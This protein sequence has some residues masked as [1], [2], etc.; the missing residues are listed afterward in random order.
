MAVRDHSVVICVYTE[1]R[2]DQICAAVQSVREQ[3]LPCAEIIVVVDYNRGL[4]ERLVA[5]M[6]DVSVVENTDAK[7]LSGARNTGLARARGEF[8]AFLDDDATAHADWLKFIN[9]SFENPAITGVGGLT[10]P[11][12]ETARPWWMPEEFFWVVG[13]NYLGMP[14]SGAPVRNLLGGNMSFRREVFELVDGFQSGIGRT[15]GGRP[16]GCE[17]TEF[18]I[19][20]RQRSPAAVLIM[21]HRAMIWHYVSAKRCA[22]SYFLSRCY[23]EGISKAQVT[24]SVGTSAG[25]SAERVYVMRTL[26][27]GVFRGVGDLFRGRPAAIGQAGAI[28]A[29]ASVTAIGYFGAKLRRLLLSAIRRPGFKPPD[30]RLHPIGQRRGGPP[31]EFLRGPLPVERTAQELSWAR[32]RE[33]RLAAAAGKPCHQ[34]GEL[35]HVGLYPGADVPD[36]GLAV[37]GRRQ[38]GRH[39]IG[40]VDVVARLLA[41]AVDGEGLALKGVDGVDRDHAGLTGCA[42]AG[43]VHV[44]KTQDG[45]RGAEEPVVQ[46]DVLLGTV[47]RHAIGGAGRRERAFR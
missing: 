45:M 38:E 1:D 5:A 14:P 13:C 24:A 40:H 30:H 43:A 46:A 33:Y 28:I 6:P 9:D 2:W 15:A 37:V 7:G 16:L 18:C 35:K 44:R 39:A 10:L 42:L 27:L 47:L 17:E 29:G 4:Y 41:V 23:A 11:N 12:W 25:L 32:W 19:R 20:L 31:P 36:A 21:D 8:I 3:S 26:P 34:R 22:F